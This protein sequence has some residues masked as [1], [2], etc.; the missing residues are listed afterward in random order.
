MVVSFQ[1]A[2][3]TDESNC[4]VYPDQCYKTR[5]YVE[6]LGELIGALMTKVKI[7]Y[8]LPYVF[9][10]T[11]SCGSCGGNYNAAEFWIGCDIC[12]WWFHG[13]CAMITPEQAEKLQQYKCPSCA[14]RKDRL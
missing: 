2:K 10:E 9:T 3:R 8:K 12:E 14:L 7:D 11:I 5:V 6:I 1:E 13:K 4:L